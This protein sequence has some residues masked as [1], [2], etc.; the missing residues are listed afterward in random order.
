MHFQS[1]QAIHAADF[2]KVC[3][4]TRNGRVLR[5]A[6]AILAPVA[7]VGCHH[8]NLPCACV[9]EC[10]AE[11]QQATQLVVGALSAIPVQGVEHHDL[12]AVDRIQRAAFMLTVFI[13]TLLMAR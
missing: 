11:K 12:A 1:D 5:L 10:A 4:V 7:E 8:L 2:K 3:D 6:A 9:L 13:V